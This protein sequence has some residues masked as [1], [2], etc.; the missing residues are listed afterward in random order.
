MISECEFEVQG[1]ELDS[2]N[3]VNNAVYLNYLEAARWHFFREVDI[4]DFMLE[5][6][7]YPVV[8]ETNIKYVRE[9]KLFDKFVV[10]SKWETDGEYIIANQDIRNKN[11]NKKSAK[12]KVKM[13]LVSDDRLICDIPE[14]LRNLING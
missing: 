2:F 3:H 5:N 13:L 10:I 7:I 14:K 11:D 4:L 1:Y 8:I 6:R 12:A 9:L